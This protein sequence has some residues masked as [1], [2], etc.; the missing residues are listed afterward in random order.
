M[1][2]RGTVNPADAPRHWAG[3]Q[4]YAR[5]EMDLGG[6]DPQV[7]LASQMIINGTTSPA[8]RAWR[9]GC[10]IGPY[11]VSS[12]ELFWTELELG[13]SDAEIR[14]GVDKL[15]PLLTIKQERRAVK[16][17]ARMAEYLVSYRDW[18]QGRLPVIH[19]TG[20]YD[21]LWDSMRADV[22]Y[23]GRYATIKL[24]EV[25]R[26]VGAVT[27]A[28]PDLRPAGA[29]S[30][31]LT[32]SWLL[33]EHADLLNG[34][35]SMLALRQ[36]VDLADGV[37]RRMSE[38]MQRDINPFTF[39]VLCCNYRQSLRDKYPGRGHDSELAAFAKAA[40]YWWEQDGGSTLLETRQRLWD[41]RCLGEWH[42][43]QGVRK[44]LGTTPSQHDYFWSDLLYSYG[45]TTDLSNPVRWD[46]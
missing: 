31:R 1:P 18:V 46:E 21:E 7:Q 14:A 16:S 13:A 12:G 45:A 20:D 6:P 2:H 22:R 8:E 15:W 4:E 42:G 28:V 39:E 25:L 23:A 32:L 41:P 3:W 26:R 27:A 9:A 40:P 37:R 19:G 11:T 35:D 5:L 10:Y 43:W 44:E 30:P 24:L 34:G 17:R 33:P 38:S 36:I 29:W